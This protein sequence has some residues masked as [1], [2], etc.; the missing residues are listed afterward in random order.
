M[1]I[2]SDYRHIRGVNYGVPAY[3][4]AV[5]DLALGK[6]IGLN[7][8]RVWL[9]PWEYFRNGE[10][11]CRHVKEFFRACRDSG[12]TVM[13]ILWNGNMMDP[14][15][16]TEAYWEEKGRDYTCRMVELLREDEALLMW[17]LMNEPEYNPYCL[18]WAGSEEEKTAHFAE[19]WAFVGR[20]AETVRSL[21]SEHPLTV[22]HAKYPYAFETEPL[23]DVISFH[24]YS[25]D[26]PN[27]IKTHEAMKELSER[28]GK[29]LIDSETGC[30]ARANP[31][32]MIVE[33]S[34]R[35]GVGYYLYELMINGYWGEIHGIFYEDG[36]VRD[37][38][39][40]AAIMGCYRNRNGERLAPD[41]YLRGQ[42][43]EAVEAL[44]FAMTE[45]TSGAF[46]YQRNPH[47]KVEPLS[48]RPELHKTRELL[49]GKYAGEEGSAEHAAVTALYER[50]ATS[51]LLDGVERLAHVLEG[52]ELIPLCD[53]P[54]AR[55]RAWREQENPD[56]DEIRI[57]AFGLLEQLK[58]ACQYLH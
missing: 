8:V 24:D 50:K 40:V 53:L 37:P 32:D 34:E 44:R 41:L 42:L 23:V 54:S 38:S 17:D 27:M 16:L 21:D 51:V 36:T 29:P 39:T 52:S 5:H 56:F 49:T 7:S 30:L 28:T 10:A 22:G 58:E 43:E 31:Y 46:G 18:K 6:R 33:C 57:Y 14:A 12:Y 13:P 3:E 15:I 2:L 55:V 48:H 11:Y 26:R 9:S 20:L 25:G 35:Y 45:A 19:L 47:G 1:K 4:K